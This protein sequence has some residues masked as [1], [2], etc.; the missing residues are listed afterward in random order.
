MKH[1]IR[2]QQANRKQRP[3]SST[4]PLIAHRQQEVH[5]Q[6]LTRHSPISMANTP[7]STLVSAGGLR[8][9][10][11]VSPTLWGVRVRGRDSSEFVGLDTSSTTSKITFH[12][13]DKDPHEDH[14]CSDRFRD[15][16]TCRHLC[17]RTT[18]TVVQTVSDLDTM[19]VELARNG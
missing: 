18:A 13:S 15:C 14:R 16:V 17:F 1:D 7:A 10:C 5:K 11:Q 8:L 19:S 12:K 3:D 6:N 4:Q 2:M 9:Y